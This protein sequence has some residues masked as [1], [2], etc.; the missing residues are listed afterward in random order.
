MHL[1]IRVGKCSFRCKGQVCRLQFK[2]RKGHVGDGCKKGTCAE[3]LVWDMCI[4]IEGFFCFLF[5]LF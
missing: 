1:P 4:H 3:T 2:A 5:I